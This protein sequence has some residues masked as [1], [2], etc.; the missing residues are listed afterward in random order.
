MCSRERRFVGSLGPRFV[1]SLGA[2]S[3]MTEVRHAR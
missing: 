3:G 2:A 1:G